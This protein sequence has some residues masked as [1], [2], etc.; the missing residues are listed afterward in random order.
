MKDLH[1]IDSENFQ[2]KVQI[3]QDILLKELCSRDYHSKQLGNTP[4]FDI[5]DIYKKSFKDVEKKY[6]LRFLTWFAEDSGYIQFL[7]ENKIGLTF[8]GRNY[9]IISQ[10][11]K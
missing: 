2:N 7:F 9:C 8:I 10:Q 6:F 3:L 4:I 11:Y 5:D 1:S